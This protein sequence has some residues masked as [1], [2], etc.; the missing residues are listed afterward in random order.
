MA[1]YPTFCIVIQNGSIL[2]YLRRMTVSP[3]DGHMS[4][5]SW[6]GMGMAFARHGSWVWVRVPWAA[7][8][9]RAWGMERL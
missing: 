5:R 2:G 6:V 7:G 8:Y 4:M 1:I 9:G 3:A